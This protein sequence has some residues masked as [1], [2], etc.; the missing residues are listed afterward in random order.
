[1]GKIRF[2]KMALVVVFALLASFFVACSD[3]ENGEQGSGD[4]ISGANTLRLSGQVWTME[5]TYDT[6]NGRRFQREIIWNQFYGD[7]AITRGFYWTGGEVNWQGEVVNGQISVTV[8]TPSESE[9]RD[10]WTSL[11][12]IRP[13]NYDNLSISDPNVRSFRVYDFRTSGGLQIV[14]ELDTYSRIGN[15]G[16]R[17]RQ[18]I[19]YVYVDRNVTVSGTGKVVSAN[20]TTTDFNIT[21]RRGW[22]TI[23]MRQEFTI[24]IDFERGIAS[25]SE[26]RS[27]SIDN[28]GNLKWWYTRRQ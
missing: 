13:A 21:L 8:N 27:V 12:I 17:T 10:I 6:I 16:F 4:G 3:D 5:Q 20:L 22:N 2:L 23:L 14:R 26:I 11:S 19:T 15:T 24:D 18:W 1:M 28:P 9:M 7:L 25:S